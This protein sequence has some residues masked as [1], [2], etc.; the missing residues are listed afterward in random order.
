MILTFVLIGPW[1]KSG[2]GFSTLDENCSIG[3]EPLS[4]DLFGRILA[5]ANIHLSVGVFAHAV[6]VQDSE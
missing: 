1:D 2:F 5:F 4:Q 6:L 3:V